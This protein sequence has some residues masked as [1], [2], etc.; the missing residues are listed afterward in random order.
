MRCWR[1][2]AIA[3]CIATAF[4][5]DHH[6]NVPPAPLTPLTPPKISNIDRPVHEFNRGM[7]PMFCAAFYRRL[8][9]LAAVMLEHA[10]PLKKNLAAA[11]VSCSNDHSSRTL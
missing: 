10:A 1:Q 5:C 4:H 8:R 6:G 7:K 9:V 2:T 3:P 11:C